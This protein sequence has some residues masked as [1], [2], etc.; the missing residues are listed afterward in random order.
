MESGAVQ[1][2]NERQFRPRKVYPQENGIAS[3]WQCR[4]ADEINPN[5]SCPEIRDSLPRSLR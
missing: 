4:T 5:H 2:G 3:G 1:L